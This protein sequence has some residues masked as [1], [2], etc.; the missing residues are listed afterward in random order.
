MTLD[1]LLTALQLGEDQEVEFKSA[2]GG[3]PKSLWE[4]VSAL[5]NT[6]GGT[7]VLGVAEREGGFALEPL[8]NPAAMRKAFWDAHNN[9]QKLS[10]PLCSEADVAL[11]PVGGTAVMT[12]QIPRATRQQ[13]P[14][15]INGNPLL[16]SYKRNHE[17]DYR[18]PESEVRRMLRDASDEAPD[19]RVLE[20][21]DRHDL[22]ADTL[23]AF[24]NRFSARD[25]DHPFLAQD[26]S[27]FLESVGAWRRDRFR[28]VEGLTL[29]GL[30]MFGKERSLLDALPHYQL[31]YQEQ[32][33]DDPQI[34]WTYR[35]TVDGKWAPNLFNFYYRVFPRLAQGV[36]TPFKTDR[37]ATRLAETH[38]HE[39]LRE[40]LV[41]TLVHADHQ[42]TLPITVI[43]RKEAF[44]FSNPGL[45]RVPR[46]QLYQGGVSDARNPTLLKMFQL[47]GLGERAGSG[48]QKIVRAWREQNWL[49]PLVAENLALETTLVNLPLA[50]MIAADVERELRALVGSAYPNL[51]ELSRMILIMAHRFGEV[52][53]QDMQPHRGEHPREI[54]ICLGQL[55]A[56]GW[57][58]KEGHG[59]GT[60]YC[61]PARAPQDLLSLI[62]DETSQVAA[63]EVTAEVTGEVTGEVTKEIKALLTEFNGEM[64][65]TQLQGHLK[66]AHE[67]HFRKAY[68]LPAIRAGLVAMTIPDKP[69]SR[70]QKY[71]LTAAGNLARAK[72]ELKNKK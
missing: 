51:D 67:D 39:A 29:A 58:N 59:R 49:V 66:L 11:V 42:S 71:K 46:D 6:E 12:I 40:A 22:D 25:H 54:G 8:G 53:N 37:Q 23:A 69:K 68:L 70:L 10:T 55:A 24:R 61:W 65:R 38:V 16:G 14:V 28:K 9:P 32:L 20:G 7:V 50:S 36:D 31:D 52:R 64:S 21:F 2:A 15:F 27:T 34:R 30:L 44:V 33:S 43:R 47:L 4:S 63:A 17:G 35:L 5:A 56:S 26:E 1:E 57:L 60:R 41:N 72:T 62:P 3:L 19:S 13:R 18:C 45:L 48:F